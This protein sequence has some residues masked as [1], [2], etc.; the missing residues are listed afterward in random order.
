ML[1]IA[2]ASKARYPLWC[3]AMACGSAGILDKRN[4]ICKRSLQ[5]VRPTCNALPAGWRANAHKSDTTVGRFKPLEN[6]PTATKKIGDHAPITPVR[7]QYLL[8]VTVSLRV[9]PTGVVFVVFDDDAE[10]L[11]AVAN[12]VGQ[13]PLFLLARLGADFDEQVD[14]FICINGT[15]FLDEA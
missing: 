8:E 2:V 15:L 12:Q 4:A 14:K 9:S 10:F 13:G 1:N 11:E 6:Y 5:A 3:V 7:Q